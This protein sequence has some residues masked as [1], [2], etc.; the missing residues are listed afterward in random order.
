MQPANDTRRAFPTCARENKID[1]P[2]VQFF[3]FSKKAWETG[4]ETYTI[5]RHPV[6]VYGLAKTI[7]DC[8][9]FRNKIGANVA[10]DALKAAVN[11]KKIQPKDIMSFAK[12][13]RVTNIIK[14]YL[15]AML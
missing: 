1:Y 3:H 13:C 7:A 5:D 4:I 8:F 15:E 11:E 14:P 10:L 6:K 2:P 9:K 12:I